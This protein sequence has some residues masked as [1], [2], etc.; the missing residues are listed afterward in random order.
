MDIGA[1][2][3][4]I[5]HA[6]AVHGLPVSVEPVE[7]ARIALRRLGLVGKCNE[8]DRRPT[9]EE[10]KALFAHFDGNDRQIIPMTRIMKFAIATAN[11][12]SRGFPPASPRYA[13]RSRR[14]AAGGSASQFLNCADTALV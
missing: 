3:L 6:A 7:L 4:V 2:K 14:V 12:A 11:R 5:S 10:L 1:I 13:S 9:K 8:R